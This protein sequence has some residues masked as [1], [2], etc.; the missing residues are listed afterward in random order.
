[1]FEHDKFVASGLVNLGLFPCS[2]YNL[3]VA[4]TTRAL[5]V[6]RVTRLRCPRLMIQPYVRALCDLHGVPF[7]TYFSTQFS[8]VFDV[9]VGTLAIVAKR[10]KAALGRD[11]PNWGLKN[12]CPAC[13]YKLEDEEELLLVVLT[14]QDGNNSLSRHRQMEC[15]EDE[16]IDEGDSPATRSRARED[17]RKVPGDYYLSQ[18]DVNKW[19]KEGLEEMMKGHSSDPEWNK[20]ED[21]CSER[22]SNMREEI[23]SRAL[24]MYDETG[25]FLPLCRH[26]FVLV[27]LDMIR[28]GELAK[29]CFAVVNHLLNIIGQVAV[30]Y[31]NGC[32][33]GKM[34]NAHPV[35]GPLAQ[36]KGFKSLVGAFHGHA[37]NRQCQLC[38]LATY[39]EGVGPEDLEECE[40]FFS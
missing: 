38:H 40:S 24:G 37:H 33:F 7:L 20:E 17:D 22:W 26:G 25:I 1:M 10:I 9:Y 31:G 3:T 36:E 12:A 21:G 39:V 6:F 23:T 18:S 2:P 27:V 32:K 11:T 4:I 34:V 29:Y 14:T 13:L 8:I 5:E 19:A 15:A 35:L 28:S 16:G 30:G